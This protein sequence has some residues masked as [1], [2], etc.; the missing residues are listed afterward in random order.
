MAAT[1]ER[2]MAAA[3]AAALDTFIKGIGVSLLLFQCRMIFIRTLCRR[4]YA[5]VMDLDHGI[6]RCRVRSRTKTVAQA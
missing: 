3:N 6:L 2:A 4:E 1:P 5:G